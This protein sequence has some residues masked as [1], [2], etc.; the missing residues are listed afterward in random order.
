MPKDPELHLIMDND[1]THK[2]AL[3]RR[4]SA[5]RQVKAWLLQRPPFMCTTPP[6]CAS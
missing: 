1:F 2:H 4:P 3:D 5:L 6:T